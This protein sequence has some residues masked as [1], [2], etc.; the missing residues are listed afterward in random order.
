VVPAPTKWR[1]R[2]DAAGELRPFERAQ[3]HFIGRAMI[4]RGW[5]RAEDL[6][7]AEALRVEIRGPARE[8]I[9][10][11]APGDSVSAA[12]PGGSAPAAA[13]IVG[14]AVREP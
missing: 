13:A 5:L 1:Y 12:A 4:A 10:P 11:A 3:M 6:P 7:A 9:A 2:F 14:R 8:L